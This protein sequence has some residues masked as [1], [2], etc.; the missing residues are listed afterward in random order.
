MRK[1]IKPR[2]SRSGRKRDHIALI[3][4]AALLLY[5]IVAHRPLA[6]KGAFVALGS[7]P[8]DTLDAQPLLQDETLLAKD[9]IFVF[10]PD[11]QG[12]TEMAASG[13]ALW[14]HEF[15]TLVTTAS[16]GK[17]FSAWGLL[18]GSVQILDESGR[19]LE[20]LNVETK[21][22]VSAYPCIY[23][24]AISET[25]EYLAILYG[26]NPQHFAI[27]RRNGQTYDLLFSQRLKNQV[28]S[29]Q[30]AAFSDDE[31]SVLIKT[32]DG[33]AFF[34]IEKNRYA[35]IKPDCFSGDS[36]LQIL[37]SG[38]QSFAFLL[39][40]GDERFT[41]SIRRGSVE[42]F[43]PVEGAIRELSLDGDILTLRGGTS[44]QRYRLGIE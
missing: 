1:R 5:L 44:V 37:P 22:I 15:G 8:P 27:F 16:I 33:L 2:L 31:A 38:A 30:A 40:R 19:K 42:A 18:D 24:A 17:R 39:A 10:R 20:D 26:R 21:G 28:L 32:A 6:Q 3:L 29:R 12:V 36:E 11:Q 9:R 43:F 14:N 7:S 25:G 23:A 34:D 4:S 35:M 41:G 13:K